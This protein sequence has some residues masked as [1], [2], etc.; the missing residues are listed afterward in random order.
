MF[1][2]LKRSVSLRRFFRVPTTNICF[3]W[4]I[5][6]LNFRFALLISLHTL[7]LSP[8]WCIIY[9]Q[10]GMVFLFLLYL[11]CFCCPYN[12]I[13]TPINSV[14]FWVHVHVSW[15]KSELRVRLARRETS[16]SPTVKYFYW[17]FQGSAS[18]VD[19]LCYFCLFLLCFRARLFI[20][21]LWSPVGKGL[22]SWLSFVMSKGGINLKEKI[23]CVIWTTMIGDITQVENIHCASWTIRIGDI[24]LLENMHCVTWAIRMCGIHLVENIHLTI[25]MVECHCI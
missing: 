17:L 6:K 8:W 14:R 16:L 5:R 22:T 25:R 19:N 3:D 10:Q 11:V 4:E 15:S 21:A 13:L 9:R 7:N 12:K 20:N 18:F 1:W 2:V 23:H 24:N